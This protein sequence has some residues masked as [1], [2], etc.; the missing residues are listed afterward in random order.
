[1]KGCKAKQLKAGYTFCKNGYTISYSG[2]MFHLVSL[3]LVENFNTLK[4]IWK[5]LKNTDSTH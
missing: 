2:G 3:H 4:E 5:H 1:M